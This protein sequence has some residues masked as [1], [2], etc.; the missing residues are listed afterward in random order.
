MK[1][2]K[3]TNTERM[4]G[5]KQQF[6]KGD[7]SVRRAATLARLNSKLVQQE[8]YHSDLWF[9]LFSVRYLLGSKPTERYGLVDRPRELFLPD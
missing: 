8:H 2:I 1:Q 5:E 7:I 6:Y 3:T 9:A 4:D